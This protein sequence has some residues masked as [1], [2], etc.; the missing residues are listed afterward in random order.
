MVGT[1]P[2]W[3]EDLVDPQDCE[4]VETA[5]ARI[6]AVLDERESIR[7]ASLPGGA[8]GL[9]RTVSEALAVRPPDITSELKS[10]PIMLENVFHLYRV[11]GKDR[12]ALLRSLQAEEQTLAEPAALAIYRWLASRELC[13]RSGRTTLKTEAL[14]DYSGFFLTTMGGQAYLRRRTPRVEAL[15]SFYALLFIDRAQRSDHD[16][17]GIDPRFQIQRT[18]ELIESQSFV[19]RD[20]YLAILD[21]LAESWRRKAE[22]R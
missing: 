18:R 6:C 3:P 15:T 9:L 21:R 1:P 12:T 11:L 22:P 16:P 2:V 20:H 7:S 4:G 19:F 13:S 10:Y 17:A 5:L 8:C 14:Y